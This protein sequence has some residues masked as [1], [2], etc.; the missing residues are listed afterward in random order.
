ML[1]LAQ[2]ATVTYCHSRTRHLPEIVASGDVVVAAVGKPRFVRG[3]WLQPGAVVVDAGYGVLSSS[4]RA[5][6]EDHQGRR[7]RQPR[8]GCA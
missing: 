3:D 1:L 6:L 7:S 8:R 5:R 2:D 4:D